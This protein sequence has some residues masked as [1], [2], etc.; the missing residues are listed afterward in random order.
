MTPHC[1]GSSDDNLALQW[2]IIEGNLRCFL[3]GRVG[4]MINRVTL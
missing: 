2:P 4:D 1:S 3:D